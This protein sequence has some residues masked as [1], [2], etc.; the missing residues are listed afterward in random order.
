MYVCTIYAN[1]YLGYFVQLESY[2]QITKINICIINTLSY[3]NNF[4]NENSNGVN[5]HT[6]TIKNFGDLFP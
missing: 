2:S 6:M 5:T 4:V 3:D 1:I